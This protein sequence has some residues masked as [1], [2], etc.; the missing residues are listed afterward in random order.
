MPTYWGFRTGG[1]TSVIPPLL[2]LG[3]TN[4]VRELGTHLFKLVV[5]QISSLT[6]D[7]VLLNRSASHATAWI[8]RW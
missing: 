5:C 1:Y 2:S 3:D 7:K 8:V 6:A 4:Q